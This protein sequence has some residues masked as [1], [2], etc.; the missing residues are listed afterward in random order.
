MKK[1]SLIALILML[2][3]SA[4]GGDSNQQKSEESSGEVQSMVSE[5]EDPMEN[6]QENKGIGPVSSVE[7]GEIDQEMAAEGQKLYEELCTACHK[8]DK[9]FIGPS[10]K[11]LLDR[12]T[13][14]WAMNMMLNPEEMIQKDPIAKQ[15]LLEAN[16]A[17]MANQNL[18]RD[19]ARKILEYI[20][21]L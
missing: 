13:P 12:R 11:G 18:T 8:V 20:R 6:W 3:I 17:P 4:C 19:Q 14:E 5:P 1:N 16:G 2:M 10:P 9:K 15:L 21:T 7:L